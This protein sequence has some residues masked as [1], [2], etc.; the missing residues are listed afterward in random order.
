MKQKEEVPVVA[1]GQ[2]TGTPY[3]RRPRLLL[4][5]SPYQA[6]DPRGTAKTTDCL[7]SG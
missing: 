6:Q 7:S 4:P 2:V 3:Q 1:P 5:L